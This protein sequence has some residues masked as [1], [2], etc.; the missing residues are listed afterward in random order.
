MKE[1]RVMTTPRLNAVRIP[2]AGSVDSYPVLCIIRTVV[3]RHAIPRGVIY[4]PREIQRLS[5]L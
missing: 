1:I 5:T 4:K 3:T 2:H